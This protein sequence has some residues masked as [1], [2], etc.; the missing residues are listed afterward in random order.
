LPELRE[1]LEAAKSRGDVQRACEV[2]EEISFFIR[3]LSRAVGL[4]RRDR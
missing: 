4:G 1:N 2:E 3:E